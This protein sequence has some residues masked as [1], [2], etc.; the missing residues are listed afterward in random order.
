MTTSFTRI[1]HL[2]INGERVA[3]Q[4]GTEAVINPATELVIGE[5]PVA[6][7]KPLTTAPG[8]ICRWRNAPP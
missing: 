3:P 2:Y 6:S 7:A 1:D 5:A 8:R 4:A